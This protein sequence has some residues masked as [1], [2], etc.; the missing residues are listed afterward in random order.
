[1]GQKLRNNMEQVQRELQLYFEIPG[2][3]QGLF[4]DS[5]DAGSTHES[6]QCSSWIAGLEKLDF[7]E[8]IA[9][10]VLSV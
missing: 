9:Q 4:K 1:M 8:M 5:G 6:S 2:E 10:T 3:P 7:E